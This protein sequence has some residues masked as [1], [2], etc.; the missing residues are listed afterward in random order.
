[1]DGALVTASSEVASSPAVN[2]QHPHLSTAWLGYPGVTAMSL[3]VDL[4]SVQE[5]GVVVVLA[6]NLSPAGTVR[7]RLSATDPAALTALVH[8]SGAQLVDPDLGGRLVDLF[9]PVMARHLRLDVADATLPQLSVGG[10]AVL[11]WFQPRHGIA[12]GW[13]DAPVERVN[14]LTTRGGQVWADFYGWQRGATFAFA[15]LLEAEYRAL[16]PAFMRHCG[17][18]RDFLAVMDPL[19]PTGTSFWGRLQRTPRWTNRDGSR[20][21]SMPMEVVEAA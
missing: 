20:L 7:V 2:V 13:E 3:T 15:N 4:L 21:F 18:R 17:S 5:V 8:D 10:L 19:D 1:M 16:A 14:A 6:A 12:F 11:P 9:D